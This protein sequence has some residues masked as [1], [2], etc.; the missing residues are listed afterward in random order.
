M[1]N[2]KKMERFFNYNLKVKE[3]MNMLMP[4]ELDF[5][6]DETKFKYTDKVLECI[7]RIDIY[8][9]KMMLEYHLPQNIIKL[10]NL[11]IKEL[12]KKVNSKEFYAV[13]K[14]G[15]DSVL[16]FIRTYISDMRVEF[17]DSIK[18]GFAGYYIYYGFDVLQ[19]TTINEFL[20]Y[21]HS[22]VINNENFYS[23]IP[24]INSLKEEDFSG[25]INLR[26]INN[27]IGNE[28]YE[29]MIK[30]EIDSDQI[31]IINL[32]NKI[33]IMARDLGHAAVLE[34]DTTDC[35]KIFIKYFIPKNT[36]QEKASK[37]KGI[38]E[39]NEKFI[40]G[41]FQTTKETF[42]YEVCS[43]MKGIPTDYDMKIRNTLM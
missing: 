6:N 33:L 19:P 34:I 8:L 38:Y 10:F 22:Y 40:T 18:K 39:N 23:E 14:Q 32:E 2:I 28:L 35:N 41:S 31:D 20:H 11:K 21:V 27:E 3:L 5:Y 12:Q 42:A 24:T 1:E 30:S 4:T 29:T 9:N 16:K 36:N 17:I 13:I 43:F 15:K 26:G 25:Q 7:E 37:L